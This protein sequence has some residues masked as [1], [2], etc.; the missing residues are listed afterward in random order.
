LNQLVHES[1][2]PY[3]QQ[4]YTIL[5]EEIVNGRWKP[6]EMMPS[7]TELIDTF[8]VSRITVRQALEKLVDDGL[9]Y[10]RRGK[11]TFVA[12]PGIEQGLSRIVSFT[13]DM[14]RRSLKPGTEVIAAEVIEAPAGI[15]E[16]L[17]IDPGEELARFERLRLADGEPMSVE[18]SHLILRYCPG[19]L[20]HDYARRPL[21]EELE[22]SYGIRLV[23]AQQVIH[24]VSTTSKLAR[25]L[26]VSKG[27]PL[28]YIE[29]VSF[30]QRDVPVEFLQLY[31]RGDRYALYNELRD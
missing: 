25:Q 30:S 29:R 14:R 22:N 10:R 9:I 11:G 4:L 24:S 17:H 2:L 26:S 3:Y 27:A 6:G 16:K 19:I 31:Y 1:P 13:E 15:A 21:R 23:R 12:I 28:F 7:E 8:E 20:N 18:V 5:R